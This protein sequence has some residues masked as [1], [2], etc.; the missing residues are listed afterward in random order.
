MA[1][2]AVPRVAVVGG[3]IAGTLASLVL[4]NRGL[5]PVLIDRGQDVGGRLRGSARSKLGDSS[6]APDAGAQFL[7]ASDVRF[8]TVLTMLESE[9]LL[10]KWNGRFGLLGNQGGGFLPTS[11]VGSVTA[12]GMKKENENDTVLST[13]AGDFC[14]FVTHH[15]DK[16]PTYAAIPDNAS[17]CP[18]I[19]RLA[20]IEQISNAAVLKAEAKEDG[21]WQ[22]QLEGE[23]TTES[24]SFDALV[25][26]SHDPTLA[27]QTVQ[28]IVDTESQ[29]PLPD[30]NNDDDAETQHRLLMDRLT[31]LVGDL[32]QTRQSKQPVFT[33]S[34][35]FAA[36]APSL[37]F[38][39]VSVPGSHLIQF[40]ARESSKPGRTK[41]M[42]GGEIWTAVSTSSL[43]Q[44]ILQRH[45]S[46][47][48][49]SEEA[50]AIMSQAVSN[51]L[52]PQNSQ[53]CVAQDGSA[54]R[55]G[56]AFTS[57]TMGLKEESI[58]LN[59]WRLA[60][61]GDFI[62]DAHPTPLEA[63]ALS[64]LEAGERVAAMFQTMM[65]QETASPQ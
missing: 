60:I 6:S 27:A 21:G 24:L 58:F 5:Y 33:W 12:A 29:A 15:S 53:N 59:P 32:I 56:A 48:Q 2:S 43:A 49:S 44:D 41:R 51:I 20:S 63:A 55:W 42:D 64:G 13:D 8:Q 10:A 34:G 39:A 47:R 50:S 17:L 31:N 38:D 19:C 9:G 62:S 7:R 54:V 26:A 25:L 37:P 36:D 11:I 3:G 61:A 52:F 23:M 14:G 4:R 1:S 18:E 57:R 40:L 30:G 45:P 65:E 22:L 46:G 16:S 35:R 28:A